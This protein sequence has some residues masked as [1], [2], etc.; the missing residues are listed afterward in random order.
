MPSLGGEGDWRSAVR[1]RI[2]IFK[3]VFEDTPTAKQTR[4]FRYRLTHNRR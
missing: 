1:K 3:R 4:L 2:G